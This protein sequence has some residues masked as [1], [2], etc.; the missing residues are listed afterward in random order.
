M[1]ISS[2][3]AFSAV[4]TVVQFGFWGVGKES[5]KESSVKVDPENVFT[6]V[7]IA[8]VLMVTQVAPCELGTSAQPGCCGI[9]RES[10][11]ESSVNAAPEKEFTGVATAPLLMSTQPGI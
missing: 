8:P 2:H 7:A 3:S 5:A 1:S 9:G 4:S 10:A 6:G 11:N